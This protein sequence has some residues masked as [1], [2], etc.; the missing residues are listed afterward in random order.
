MC[1]KILHIDCEQRGGNSG[2]LHYEAEKCDNK[3]KL[4]YNKT[5]HKAK[6]SFHALLGNL[7]L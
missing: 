7:T 4:V 6:I 5:N 2:F 1:F 3:P